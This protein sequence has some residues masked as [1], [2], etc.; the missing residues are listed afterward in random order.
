MFIDR[1]K[2]LG[3]SLLTLSLVFTVGCETV[4]PAQSDTVPTE[5]EQAQVQDSTVALDLVADTTNELKQLRERVELLEF[6]L[7]RTQKRMTQLYDDIDIRLR[8]L[9]RHSDSQPSTSEPTT[10]TSES[11]APIE[12]EASDD[13]STQQQTTEDSSAEQPTSDEEPVGVIQIE[14]ASEGDREVYDKAFRSLRDGEYED[15]IA[16]FGR[17]VEQ[18]P[19]SQL[20][21]DSWYWIAEANYV[22]QNYEAALPVFERVVEEYPDSQRA[23]DSMLK[24]G[25][26]Y[27]E[28][29]DF[30]KAGKYLNQVI[31]LYPASRS[32][33]S[34]RRRLDKMTRDG[35]L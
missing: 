19:N 15:A 27:Y 1:Y 20:L 24:I 9:E 30:E 23:S 14:V 17:L 11:S 32:A 22:T 2:Y 33:F 3:L 8:K 21:D 6:E 12:S 34:A 26:V 13:S 10:D 7:N 16:E 4:P 31:E 35:V 18:F 25:Y 5:S 29:A 28:M